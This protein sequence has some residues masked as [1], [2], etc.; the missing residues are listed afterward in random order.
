MKGSHF[1]SIAHENTG[2]NEAFVS[3]LNKAVA[4]SRFPMLL[5]KGVVIDLLGT[6]NMLF[7]GVQG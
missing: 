7:A 1:S 6:A 5:G 3:A 2:T 4:A